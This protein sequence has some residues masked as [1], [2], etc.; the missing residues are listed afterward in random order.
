MQPWHALFANGDRKQPG[1]RP[2]MV[3]QDNFVIGCKL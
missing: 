1:H 2:A 3:D